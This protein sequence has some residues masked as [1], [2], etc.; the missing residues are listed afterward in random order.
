MALLLIG[1]ASAL[2]L[3][4]LNA[5]ADNA[6]VNN[7]SNTALFYYTPFVSGAGL[8]NAT[9]WHNATGVWQAQATEAVG[10]SSGEVNVFTQADAIANKSVVWNVLACDEENACAFAPVNRTVNVDQ[11]FPSVFLNA[12]ADGFWSNNASGLVVFYATPSEIVFGELDKLSLY[13]SDGHAF[14][15]NVSNNS[16]VLNSSENVLVLSSGIAN[17]SVS[18]LIE[19]CDA[20]GN[21]AASA[22]R[23]LHADTAFPSVALTAPAEEGFNGNASGDGV[24]F[25]F[26]PSDV[27]SGK[28]KNA[29]LFLNSTEGF[30]AN[31]SNSSPLFN[32]S[33]NSINVTS[34]FGNF[35]K[36]LW[37]VLVCDEAGNCDFAGENHS[38][39]KGVSSNSIS[40]PLKTESGLPLG[41]VTETASLLVTK[42]ASGFSSTLSFALT[43]TGNSDLA[44]VELVQ[45]MPFLNY[46]GPSPD[47][48]PF[49]WNPRPLSIENGSVIA[50][51]L[52]AKVKPGEVVAAEVTVNKKVDEEEFKQLPIPKVISMEGPGAGV[53]KAPFQQ[54]KTPEV[55]E[56]GIE[57]PVAIML[58]ILCLAYL[59]IKTL[60]RLRA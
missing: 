19:A 47:D 3:V 30:T 28:L 35:Q 10:L 21:C 46:L 23:V 18:W 40:F 9:L 6:W 31:T 8:K 25:Y 57:W 53:K 48:Y 4:A 60:P 20:A 1:F 36:I 15:F 41:K 54:A 33:S 13:L 11:A 55:K 52:F 42:G 7:G 38:F 49:E 56:A 43:N 50:A 34:G 58:A 44:N 2:P 26:T 29:T 27:V 17:N 12:P 5:P 16:A 32:H 51:W 24:V 39:T 45:E 14:A 37:N 59:A 22:S